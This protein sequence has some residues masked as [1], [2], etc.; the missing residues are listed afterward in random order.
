MT[1]RR[2]WALTTACC[3]LLALPTLL[4]LAAL[5]PAFA[6]WWT[7]VVAGA[8]RLAPPLVASLQAAPAT[9]YRSAVELFRAGRALVAPALL[10]ARAI[11]W[12]A[13]LLVLVALLALSLAIAGV[14]VLAIARRRRQRFAAAPTRIRHLAARGAVTHAIARRTGLPQD[15]VRQLLMPQPDRNAALFAD[16]LASA[17]PMTG[18]GGTVAP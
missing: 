15:A 17:G 14:L 12:R 11:D 2:L 5:A 4:R 8:A 13:A 7:A 9:A 10:L 1:R 3:A 6:R 18:A 16:L